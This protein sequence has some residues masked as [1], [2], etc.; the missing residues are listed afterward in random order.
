[1]LNTIQEY[2]EYLFDC[3]FMADS[4]DP[5]GNEEHLKVSWECLEKFEWDEVFTTWEAYLYS[6]CSSVEAVINFVNLY[7]Y[8][9][10]S[11]KKVHDAIKFISYL[12]YKV[13]IDKYWDEAGEL[14]YSLTIDVLSNNG[15]LS[16]VEAVYYDPLDD[17]RITAAVYRWKS[18]ELF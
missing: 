2:T 8:Y 7:F 11:N 17:P 9:D 15:F 12:F 13:D 16:Q 14:F 5:E 1:M 18:G 3:D 6:K 10:C 4:F